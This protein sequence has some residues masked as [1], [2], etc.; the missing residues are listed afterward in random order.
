LAIQAL[1]APTKPYGTFNDA[2]CVVFACIDVSLGILSVRGLQTG[3]V[4]A[5]LLSGLLPNGSFSR[6]N[7]PSAFFLCVALYGSASLLLYSIYIYM[8][9]V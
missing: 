9:F 1:R 3:N 8:L 5:V 4:F 6:K 7:E 2:G